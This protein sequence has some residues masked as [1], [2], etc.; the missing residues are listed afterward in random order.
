M[1]F[2][3]Q[4]LKYSPRRIFVRVFIKEK[5]VELWA[6]SDQNK[7]FHR[8]RSYLIEELYLTAVEAR[9]NGQKMIPVHIFPTQVDDK[10]M[11]KLRTDFR[12]QPKLIS[13]WEN[14]KE[15]YGYFEKNKTVPQIRVNS[16]GRYLFPAGRS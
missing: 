5:V 12:D 1:I 6:F 14:L 9:T 10:Y 15:G 2:A 3:E 4:G 13:F 7:K 16:R 11:D 8:I